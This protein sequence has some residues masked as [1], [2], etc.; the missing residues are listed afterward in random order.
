MAL[1]NND[2]RLPAFIRFKNNTCCS[3]EIIWLNVNNKEETYGI[4]PP[5]KFLDVNTYSTHPWIFRFE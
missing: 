2:P 1:M 5:N 4:L 3:V